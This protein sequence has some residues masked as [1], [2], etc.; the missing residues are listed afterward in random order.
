[1]LRGVLDTP[2]RRSSAGG[3]SSRRQPC[4]AT[5]YSSSSGFR[6]RPGPLRSPS[7]D[8]TKKALG[9]LPPAGSGL[10]APAPPVEV[11]AASEPCDSATSTRTP[12]LASVPD[13]SP[14]LSGAEP[15]TPPWVRASSNQLH[16]RS[17][18]RRRTTEPVFLHGCPPSEG[19]P[20][21]P[22]ARRFL[23]RGPTNRCQPG[24]PVQS[25]APPDASARCA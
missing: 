23:S 1:V 14:V 11:R 13:A 7:R 16:R 10:D 3:R 25:L 12:A 20:T 17:K 15:P 8:M 24:S 18:R 5:P 19:S 9:S 21:S 2:T 4:P 22:S 6:L